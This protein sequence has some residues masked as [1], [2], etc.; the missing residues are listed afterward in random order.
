[1]R[2]RAAALAATAVLGLA[3][4][5]CFSLPEFADGTL[6]CAGDACPPAYRCAADG[7][8]HRAGAA[9]DAAIDAPGGG[10]GDGP[11]CAV[12]LGKRCLDGRPQT[13]DG[14]GRWVDASACAA[15]Q[16][17]DSG[18]CVAPCAAD[19]IRCNGVDLREKCIGG[20]WQRL[21]TCPFVCAV[22]G[23]EGVC[24]PGVQRCS[25]DGTAEERC[26]TSGQWQT[27]RTCLLQCD[28]T[29][30]RCGGDCQAGEVRCDGRDRQR[31][32]G[33]SWMTVETCAQTC[34]N[35]EC[36]PCDAAAPEKQCAPGDVLQTCQAGGTWNAGETCAFV[37][38]DRACTGVCKPQTS[39]CQGQTL[40]TCGLDGTYT[41]G[42]TCAVACVND[43][44]A[45]CRAGDH[46]CNPLGTATESC[47]GGTWTRDAACTDGC[48]EPATCNACNPATFAST[49]QS[50]SARFVCNPATFTV[51]AVACAGATPACLGG[52][53]VACL[54]G[55][56]RCASSNI[57]RCDTHGAW[58]VLQ[59]CGATSCIDPLPLG[60]TD[61]TCGTCSAGAHRC[62]GGKLQTCDGGWM[63]TQ[64]CGALG[65]VDPDGETGPGGACAECVAGDKRCTGNQL[66]SCV[67]GAF[68]PAQACTTP[69]TCFDPAPAGGSDAY[70]GVCANN[71]KRC[72]GATLQV[73][74]AGAWTDN[75]TCASA[76]D[77]FDPD[78]AAGPG[79]ACSTCTSGNLQ[80][81][82]NLLQ[83][84]M[85]GSF[86]TA[87]DCGAAGTQCIDPVPQGGT[88]AYCG[89]C[90]NGAR[91]CLGTGLEA[92]ASGAWT[93]AQACDSALG[94]LD[95]DGESG[96]GGYCRVCTDNATRCSNGN[97]ETCQVGQWVPRTPACS[98]TPGDTCFDPAPAGD[99]Y[100][101]NCVTGADRCSPDSPPIRQTCVGGRW[102]NSQVCAAVGCADPSGPDG[103]SP[104]AYCAECAAGDKRCVGTTFQTCVAQLWATQACDTGQQCFDPGAAGGNDAYCGVC[105]SGGPDRC[106]GAG[107]ERCSSDGQ[108]WN[109]QTTCQW[110]CTLVGQAN[111]PAC[112]GEPQCEPGAQCGDAANVC[113]VT[114]SC[115]HC[116][117][118]RM[119]CTNL[120][121]PLCALSCDL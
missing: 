74:V 14:T 108:G 78:G 73:C 66:D 95:P 25:T 33:S 98:A 100:C 48:H 121:P 112:C 55:S 106:G 54:P 83:R 71:A 42:M 36:R 45:E 21:E 1:M 77:C 17:C 82:G 111:E 69:Q 85:G 20:T 7:F 115:G 50:D 119:C 3:L 75:Q 92:C 4:A 64:T 72:S 23:C 62:A 102:M 5:S 35:G 53:C 87:G 27:W 120:S 97:L 52:A 103:A 24:S 76:A 59:T 117:P 28:S 80:C 38:H 43:R 11:E 94:C 49:C 26:D 86:M 57:E 90:L 99:A 9:I 67:S 30:G 32:Q 79:G 16:V 101:G 107:I 84:C 37:C 60:G 58:Q 10:G 46:R 34:S 12:G 15:A 22:D 40:E 2:L 88:D 104:P 63:D 89:V 6:R 93:S 44:C 114:V 47:V 51:E 116:A 8:C 91:R 118:N 109:P 70:C 39:T 18:D 13:C 96:P 113:G 29:S 110:G 81:S 31:C 61:Q 19:A 105:L 56:Q 65:C 68:Q 41:N